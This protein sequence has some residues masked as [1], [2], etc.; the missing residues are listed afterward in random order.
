MTN[1]EVLQLVNA[2]FT[3]DE[4]RGMGLTKP[5]PYNEPKVGEPKVGE[6]DGNGN[7]PDSQPGTDDKPSSGATLPSEVSETIK[8]LT[9]TVNS[10]TQ[11]VKALQENNQK[12]A[13]KSKNDNAP[14][15][16][17]EVIKGFIENM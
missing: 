17:D 3:A 16:A 2:G 6:P 9:E 11:T 4:I 14:K 5:S 13:K 15:S 12:T 1:E 10:L 7:D 8:G